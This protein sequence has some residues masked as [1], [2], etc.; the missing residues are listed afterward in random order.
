[1]THYYYER[2]HTLLISN[3][4]CIILYCNIFNQTLMNVQLIMEDAIKHVITQMVR[5]FVPVSMDTSSIQISL[6]VKTLM[7]VK[8]TIHVLK[9]VI[10]P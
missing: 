2:E 6:P 4:Y 5:T 3:M 10:I 1:M 9:I 8:M 7:S